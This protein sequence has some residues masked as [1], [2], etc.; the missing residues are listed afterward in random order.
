MNFQINF[1]LMFILVH[2][3]CPELQTSVL[4]GFLP[5]FPGLVLYTLLSNLMTSLRNIHTCK[6]TGFAKKTW[7]FSLTHCWLNDS[8]E[9]TYLHTKKVSVGQFAS[10]NEFAAAGNWSRRIWERAAILLSVSLYREHMG[11]KMQDV[12]VWWS[13]RDGHV[14]RLPF[15]SLTSRWLWACRMQGNLTY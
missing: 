15:W 6:P 11:V 8:E 1:P 3:A 12:C 5:G 2:Y 9:I 13:G 10:R 7:G 4:W 14:N